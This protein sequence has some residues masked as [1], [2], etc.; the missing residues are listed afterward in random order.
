MR[1]CLRNH[2]ESAGR[3]SAERSRTVL[4]SGETALAAL[5]DVGRSAGPIQISERTQLVFL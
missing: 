2:P 5:K 3:I 4:L 1:R